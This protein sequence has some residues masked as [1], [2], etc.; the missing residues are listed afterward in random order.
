M[1]S[2]TAADQTNSGKDCSESETELVKEEAA[3]VDKKKVEAGEDGDEEAKVS[4]DR[5]SPQDEET[6][7]Q[8][9]LA[10]RHI[11]MALTKSS[12][13]EKYFSTCLLDEED[14][15]R[16]ADFDSELPD[17]LS[18]T[19]FSQDAKF[20]FLIFTAFLFFSVLILFMI[21][22][23]CAWHNNQLL[24]LLGREDFTQDFFYLHYYEMPERRASPGLRV[25][26]SCFVH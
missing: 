14:E 16:F 26:T 10:S 24:E 9:V 15:A 19:F 6:E 2:C 23:N 17:F 22:A 3:K 4:A 20:F 12:A 1:A 25:N 13:I 7:K 8:V 5:L 11:T 21:Q 18:R